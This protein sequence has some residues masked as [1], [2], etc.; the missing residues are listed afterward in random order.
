M[1][2]PG[3]RE[4]SL[5]PVGE[6]MSDRKKLIVPDIKGPASAMW[7]K[8]AAYGGVALLLVGGTFGLVYLK[9]SRQAKE[10]KPVIKVE[11]GIDKTFFEI[12]PP[13]A[14]EVKEPPPPPAPPAAPRKIA[15]PV[16]PKSPPPKARDLFVSSPVPAGRKVDSRIA[17][18]REQS[19]GAVDLKIAYTPPDSTPEWI[20]KD[21]KWNEGRIETSYPVDLERAI[22]VDRM[23][24]ALLVNEVN[25][26]LGGK[27]IA[28]IENNVYGAHGRKVL[29]PAGSKAIGQ[30]K[31]L[32]KVGQERLAI[33]WSRIITP[34]GINIHT[35]NAEMTDAIGRAGVTGEVDRRYWD[36]FGMALLTSVGTAITAYS[37]PVRSDSQQVVVEGF[38]REG[39]SL[40]GSILKE[41]ID[42][43]PRV[44]IPAGSRI[45]ITAMKDIWFPMPKQREIYAVGL[46]EAKQK[47][48]KRK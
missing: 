15:Q 25:S 14:P 42:I 44:I 28:V 13:P 10:E 6:V 12:I 40:A 21:E 31:P 36:R 20:T 41:Q 37:I 30:Y 5:C 4:V 16:P 2:D 8:V 29:I 48:G 23:I 32:D 19:R 24:P 22:T 35:A 3:R 17:E 45:M 33:L 46:D 47:E 27:V 43:K 11:S 1:D 18:I 34:E 26:E 9:K 38:G 39:N 7:V